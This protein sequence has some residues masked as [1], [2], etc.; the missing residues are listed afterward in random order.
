[1][2]FKENTVIS[3]IS[4]RY[5]ESDSIEE[6]WTKLLKGVELY[7]AD[8]RR[9]PLGCMNLPRFTGKLKDISRLDAEFFGV[10]PKEANFMDPQIRILHEAIYEAIWDSG[11]SPDSLRGSKTGFFVGYCYDDTLI[12]LREDE[13]NPPEY[14]ELGVARISYAFDWNGPAILI[15]TACASSFSA[16]NQALLS[17][18]SGDCDQA[19]VAGVGIQLWPNTSAAFHQLNMLSDDGKSKCLDSSADG[20]CRSEAVVAMFVQKESVSKRIYARIL[21]CQTNCDGYKPEGITF[22]KYE[23]QLSLMQSIYN[24]LGID[25]LTIDYV[26]AHVTGTKAGDPV[27]SSALVKALRPNSDKTLLVG[28]L[29][30]NMG[31][32][33]GASAL[34][35]ITKVVKIFQNGLIPPNINF[36]EPN[37]FIESLIKGVIKPVLEVTPYEKDLIAVNS[38]GF[39]GVN[40]H[41]VLAANPKRTTVKDKLL[42]DKSIPRLVNFNNR[43]IQ[44]LTEIE[45]FIQSHKGK[46]TCDLLA[47]LNDVSK[48]EPETG[49]KHRGYLIL[50]NN[51]SIIMSDYG[52]TE[53]RKPLWIVFPPLFSYSVDLNL[54]RQLMSIPIIH[55][56]IKSFN[57]V[58]T[59]FGI[60]LI[61][62]LTQEN[63]KSSREL[64]T[65]LVSMVATQMALFEF[66]KLLELQPDGIMGHSLGEIAAAYADQCLTG[67]QALLVAYWIGVTCSQSINKSGAMVKINLDWEEIE[68]LKPSDVELSSLDSKSSTIITGPAD[69]ISAFVQ[70]LEAKYEKVNCK[71]LDS[72]KI[73]FNSSIMESITASVATKLSPI[74]TNCKQRSDAWLI[75]SAQPKRWDDYDCQYITANYFIRLLKSP[76]YFYEASTYLPTNGIFIEMGSSQWTLDVLSDKLGSS[77]M[78][79][80]ILGHEIDNSSTNYQQ[81]ILSIF[82]SIGE[83]YIAGHNPSIEKLYPTVKYPVSRETPSIGHLLQWDHSTSYLVT[84]FPQYYTLQQKDLETI[85]DLMNPEWKFIRGHCIDGR[86]L[87]PATGYL[88]IVWCNIAYKLGEYCPDNLPIEFFDVKLYRAT[89]ISLNSPAKFTVYVNEKGDHFTIKESDTICATGRWRIPKQANY[90]FKNALVH[91]PIKDN[92]ITLGPKDIYKEFRVRG[93]DYGDSFQGLT[94]ALSDGSWGRI[95]K[96]T[97]WISMADS[98]LQISLLGSSDRKLYLPNYMEYVFINQKVTLESI[99]SSRRSAPQGTQGTI[100]IYFDRDA[101]IGAAPGLLIKGAKASPVG[102]RQDTQIA[103]LETTM[104]TPYDQSISLTAKTSIGL[105]SYSKYCSQCIENLRTESPIDDEETIK[106]MLSIKDESHTLLNILYLACTTATTDDNQNTVK[107]GKGEFRRLIE[108]NRKFLVKDMLMKE[109]LKACLEPQLSIIGENISLKQIAVS[110]INFSIDSLSDVINDYFNFIGIRSTTTFAVPESLFAFVE[111]NGPKVIQ[112]HNDF[113]RMSDIH[114]SDL[115][116]LRD[117]QVNF[118]FQNLLPA[119]VTFKLKETLEVTHECLKDGGFI[120][121]ITRSKL[122]LVEQQLDSMIAQNEFKFKDIESLEST[123]KETGFTLI[124]TKHVTKEGWI[125][126]LARKCVPSEGSAFSTIRVTMKNYDWVTEL[127]EKLIEK[128]NKVWLVGTGSTNG[129]LGLTTCLRKEPRGN[130][131]RCLYY[132]TKEE[133]EEIEIP[134]EILEKD[135]AFNII[136]GDCVGTLSSQLLEDVDEFKVDAKDRY[137]DVK[138]KGDLSSFRWFQAQFDTWP[139]PLPVESMKNNVDMISVYYGSLNFKDVMVASGRIPV[140]AYPQNHYQLVESHVGM[141]YSGIDANGDRVMGI[142]VGGSI[143][144]SIMIDSRFYRMKIPDNWTLAEAATIPVVYFTAYYGLIIRGNLKR[145]ESVLIHAGSGGVGQAAISICLAMDCTVFTTVGTQAK[146]DF[147]K[148]RYPAIDDDHIADSRSTS[149]E[150]QIM[151][152]T[153]GHGVDLVLNSL[154]E[155]KFKASIR[156]LADCGRFIEIGKYDLVQDTKIDSTILD[157]NKS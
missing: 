118:N 113:K 70:K 67:E 51:Q 52:E 23:T 127:K 3:G 19:I 115:I 34:C 121:F 140:N 153:N 37:P 13:S 122:S 93:Y 2:K 85:V 82:K 6:F 141:E 102:R 24:S 41:S 96:T 137:I 76:S 107:D 18:I 28:C 151:K 148:Q 4:G 98:C 110:D 15:D 114:S 62:L 145:G 135:L 55:E 92:A 131:L 112:F 83:I 136:N 149:F 39:G 59:P 128:D 154:A 5:P 89:I 142:C 60:N 143:G 100:D 147:I 10:N 48:I 84:K 157:H 61:E 54:S 33:E 11:V 27:E 72:F 103:R 71:W 123:F 30:S 9:W 105:D 99:E 88:Y 77:S 20:Y 146:R 38:F 66:I 53:R 106:R 25:P 86:I 50:D 74:L 49:L 119:D 58:L 42:S 78:R 124:A 64:V 17:I 44:G 22:P 8:D 152:V 94:E 116:V 117:D 104:F 126:I 45:N 81:G 101:N 14:L 87:F 35:A 138:T 68:S 144:T 108:T 133:D 91:R 111:T 21:D 57:S 134:D 47:L 65:S 73:P 80:S 120:L 7:T 79:M 130:L 26:E 155:D 90:K 16:L 150:E 132:P 12:A 75:T 156:C 125:S 95:K 36:N 63:G 46:L 109:P 129:I 139:S 29:K 43:T 69:S 31:H 97:H 40:V 1:M 32:S 56:K